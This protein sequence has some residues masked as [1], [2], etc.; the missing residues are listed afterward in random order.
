MPKEIVELIAAG[1]CRTKRIKKIE[2]LID[3]KKV[4]WRP[5]NRSLGSRFLGTGGT[6]SHAIVVRNRA[7]VI[8]YFEKGY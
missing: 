2:I 6:D 7:S 5:F 3:Q 8:G 4:H 1:C